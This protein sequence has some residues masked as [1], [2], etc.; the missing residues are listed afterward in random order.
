[1]VAKTRAAHPYQNILCIFIV[2][3]W[4]NCPSKSWLHRW[5]NSDGVNAR[6]FIRIA[7]Q[8]MQGMSEDSIVF[9]DCLI[10]ITMGNGGRHSGSPQMPGHILSLVSSPVLFVESFQSTGNV[11]TRPHE[12]VVAQNRGQFPFYYDHLGRSNHTMACNVEAESFPYWIGITSC[13]STPPS[14]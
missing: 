8:S 4:L 9:G 1:M 10:L 14:S 13:K 3:Y 6:V 7:L 12:Y 5:F 11:F 2:L